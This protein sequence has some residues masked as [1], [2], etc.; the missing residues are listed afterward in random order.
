MAHLIRKG[1]RVILRR[2]SGEVV[3]HVLREDCLFYEH[4]QVAELKIIQFRRDGWLLSVPA[5]DITHVRFSCPQ[6]RRQVKWRSKG[7]ATTAGVVGC[8]DSE[9]DRRAV[10]RATARHIGQ[11][12]RRPPPSEQ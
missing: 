6:C 4:N 1:T 9:T 2:P 12:V 5:A 10:Q 7:S 3:E 8:R 11:C